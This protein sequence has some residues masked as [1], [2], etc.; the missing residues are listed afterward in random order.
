MNDDDD[1]NSIN[2][3]I[4]EYSLNRKDSSPQESSM[5]ELATLLRNSPASG[6]S[7]EL[8]DM[9]ANMAQQYGMQQSRTGSRASRP[10]SQ[11]A[12]RFIEA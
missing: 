2:N 7:Q 4:G 5:H 3:N 12:Q 11:V 1:N 8:I 6:I 10:S 9:L